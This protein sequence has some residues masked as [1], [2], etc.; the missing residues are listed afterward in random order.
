MKNE[1]ILFEDQDIK[2]EVNLQDETVWLSLDQMIQLFNRNKSVI[3]RHIKNILA[4]ELSNSVIAKFAT[5][6]RD[7][8]V[9]N[10]DYYNLDMIISVGYRVKSKNGI[11]FRKWANKILKDYL[12]KGHAINNKRLEYLEKTIKLIDIASRIDQNL[13]NSESQEIIRVIN[14]YS[15]AFNLLDDYDHQR[16]SKPKG[17]I[18]YNKITYEDCLNVI[19]S[20]KFD[21]KS[22][23]FA[24]ERNEGLKSILGAIYQSF[25]GKD[26]YPS[27]EEKAANLLYLI[28]KNHVF[29]D[30]NKRIAATLFIYFLNFYNLLY[31]NGNQVIDNNALVGITLLIAQSD[32]K[33]KDILVDLVIN[34]LN[35]KTSH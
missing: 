6:A 24:L 27:I 18:S 29:I 33:E 19:R 35:Y 17:N 9:Y 14:N 15:K 30:G 4:E 10:V 2:L 3:F 7:G 21:E 12:I 11:I 26:V 20:L 23:L 22:K 34:F 16:L 31:L 25:D 28:T 8:K 1:I 13:E 5:T 32:P